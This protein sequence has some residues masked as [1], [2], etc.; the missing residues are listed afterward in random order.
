MGEREVETDRIPGSATF[1][2][3]DGSRMKKRGFQVRRRRRIALWSENRCSNDG[4]H[5]CEIEEKKKI[6]SF[7]VFA[8]ERIKIK[9][10]CV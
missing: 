2:F 7:A 10:R 1:A 9:S 4:V 6:A 5:L 3:Q 8:K